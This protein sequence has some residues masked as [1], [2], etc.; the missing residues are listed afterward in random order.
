[1]KNIKSLCLLLAMLLCFTVPVH[2][3]AILSN[4]NGDVEVDYWVKADALD[5]GVNFRYGA[6]V[7]YDKIISNMIPNGVILHITGERTASTGRKWGY[8]EYQGMWGYVSLS[9]TSSYDKAAADKAAAEEEA[10]LKAEAEEQE[11]LKAEAE[12][13]E[14]LKA[15]AEEQER[16]KAEA[17]EQER[18]KAEAE[19]Q[20]KEDDSE[21]SKENDKNTEDEEADDEDEDEEDGID[22]GFQLKLLAVG[23]ACLIAAITAG[24]LIIYGKKRRSAKEAK[25]QD[26]RPLQKTTDPQQ[27]EI[28]CKYCGKKNNSGSIYCA[29]CG[30][31]IK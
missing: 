22:R 31:K 8:T 29:H 25:I 10:R 21:D 13:Q 9:Q 4:S 26:E 18:L 23:A 30:K 7:E 12:E 1:M 16:L 15:E 28:F 20:K 17:E 6:G 19:E 5:G 3:D 24:S 2:A 11:R 27:R 14:R